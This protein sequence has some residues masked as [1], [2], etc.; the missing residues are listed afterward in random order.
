MKKIITIVFLLLFG[1]LLFYTNLPVINYGF[2]GFAIILLVLVILGVLLS[3]GLTVS[4]QTKQVKIVSR[5]NKVLYVFLGV[6]LVY[7]IA[8]PFVTSLKMFRSES[9]QNFF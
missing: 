6:I 5:P 9:Y 7:C 3:L 4:Q 2:T 1:F 8:L